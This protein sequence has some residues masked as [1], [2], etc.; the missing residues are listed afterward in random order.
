MREKMQSTDD[1][2]QTAVGMQSTDDRP[3]TTVLIQLVSNLPRIATFI[4]MDRGLRTGIFLSLILLGFFITSCVQPGKDV[5]TGSEASAD[6]LENTYAKGFKIEKF[7]DF[8]VLTVYNPWQHAQGVEYKYVLAENAEAVPDS[9]KKFDFIQ[10]PVKR[11]VCLSTTH[12]A[13]LK[14]LNELDAIC[15]V[16]APEFIYDSLI[17]EKVKAG[18]ISNVGYDQAM[19][20]E[21]IISLKPDFVMAYGVG[22]ESS[23]QFQRLKQ[24]GVKVVF[25]AEYLEQTPLG[26]AEWLNFVG[27]FF[28]KEDSA[29]QLF[30]TTSETYT[31]LA[32]K[33]AS[34]KE[35][36]MVLSGLPWKGVWYVPGGKSYASN[37]IYDAGGDYLWKEDMG[38]ESIPLSLETVLERANKAQL[39]INPGSALNLSEMALLDPRIKTIRSLQEKKV[40]NFNRRLSPGGGNDF[41]ESGVVHPDLILKDLIAIFHPDLIPNHTFVYYQ[42]LN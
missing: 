25:N 32:Q 8:K 39:W 5:N 36:P 27:A 17:R 26:K 9:L 33:A 3:Q 12:L 30:K 1:G 7:K 10:I 4:A 11:I 31:N 28:N 2:R 15:G 40:F 23:G 19:N 38:S 37:F 29:A 18:K 16:S 24:L 14:E 21:T 34:V 20:I 41:W 13:F 35:K 22:S 42:L 6:K